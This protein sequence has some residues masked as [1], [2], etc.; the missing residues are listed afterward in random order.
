QGAG[1]ADLAHDQR[2]RLAFARQQRGEAVAYAERCRADQQR[3]REERRDQR[4]QQGEKG[5]VA[6]RGPPS[7]SRSRAAASSVTAAAVNGPPQTQRASEL[8]A[9]ATSPATRRRAG[10]SSEASASERP[11]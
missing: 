6:H 11:S 4:R 1:Q 3:R 10:W 2:R 9:P 7:I 8:A 5:A